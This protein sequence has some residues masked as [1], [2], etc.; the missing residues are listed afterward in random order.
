MKNYHQ[1]ACELV[2]I[3]IDGFEIPVGEKFQRKEL[4]IS[5]V[6]QF[7]ISREVSAKINETDLAI[8][9]Q[10]VLGKNSKE[11]GAAIFLSPRTVEARIQQIKTIFGARNQAQLIATAKDYRVL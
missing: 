2:D 7:L 9:Q 4:V 6:E 10:M 1:T 11:I 3:M 8:L 5:Q